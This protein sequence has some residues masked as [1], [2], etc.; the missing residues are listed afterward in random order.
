VSYRIEPLAGHDRAGFASGSDALDRYFR[1]QV[2]QD[3]RRRLARCF[4]AVEKDAEI[5]G[6]Y[7]ICA[8]S[9]A[10]ET[11]PP[12]RMKKLPRYSSIPAVL[13]GRL[14]IS[15]KHQGKGL[16]AAL[17]V[18]ACERAARSELAAY[19]MLVDAIDESAARFYEHLGFERLSDPHRLFRPLAGLPPVAR[20]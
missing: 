17:V 5:A 8:T 15:S 2:T 4:V 12:S 14:A 9:V 18:D 19:A 3:I 16:G 20:P 13:L 10:P 6:Y 1:E 11:L 7:T